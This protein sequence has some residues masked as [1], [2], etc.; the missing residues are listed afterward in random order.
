MENYKNMR[1]R[2]CT[3]AIGTTLILTLSLSGCSRHSLAVNQITAEASTNETPDDNTKGQQTVRYYSYLTGLE[4]AEEYRVLRP[5]SFCLNGG[6][7]IG[8]SAARAEILIEAPCG[9]GETRFAVITTAYADMEKIGAIASAPAYL[10][11]M[12]DS[13][14]PMHVYSGISGDGTYACTAFDSGNSDVGFFFRDTASGTENNLMANGKKIMESADS[15]GYVTGQNDNYASPFAFSDLPSSLGGKYAKS[16]SVPY[17]SDAK[18]TFQY[19]ESTGKY[20][21]FRNGQATKDADGNDLSYKNVFV[22][23]CDTTTTISPDEKKYILNAEKGG[24]GYYASRGKYC[25]IKWSRDS[26]GNLKLTDMSGNILSASVGNTYIGM[27]QIENA[28][29]IYIGN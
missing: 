4:T 11:A 12:A 3:A 16:I 19:D 28:G 2:I 29:N 13:F 5:V 23:I 7:D 26:Y 10:L 25:E 1:W 18:Y 8:Y 21:R 15:C 14:N 17:F 24:S 20:V 22:L 6:D 9:N 27:L